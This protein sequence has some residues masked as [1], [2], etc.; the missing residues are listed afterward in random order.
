VVQ[1]DWKLVD[2][3]KAEGRVALVFQRVRWVCNVDYSKQ[4][5]ECEFD[6]PDA[7]AEEMIG[8]MVFIES[9]ENAARFAVGKTYRV[10]FG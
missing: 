3:S 8:R 4:P 1:V 10:T 2:S 9:V 6:H 7:L 5:I